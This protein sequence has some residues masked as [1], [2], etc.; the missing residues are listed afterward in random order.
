MCTGRSQ[1]HTS[2]KHCLF[3]NKIVSLSCTVLSTHKAS[4]RCFTHR[5][6]R[7]AQFSDPPSAAT[8]D[9]RRGHDVAVGTTVAAGTCLRGT[10]LEQH[11]IFR[12][13][14]LDEHGALT[15]LGRGRQHR[16]V[17]RGAHEASGLGQLLL[18]GPGPTR[19]DWH[20][21]SKTDHLG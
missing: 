13:Q 10:G 5:I 6:A 21:A 2:G 4:L 8:G 16:G 15:P 12:F 19:P 11:H 18:G 20:W 17:A 7:S 3:L 14:L 1:T 9:F